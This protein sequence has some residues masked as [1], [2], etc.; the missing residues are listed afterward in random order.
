MRTRRA[1]FALAI[2]SLSGQPSRALGWTQFQSPQ[3]FERPL[4]L[5][6]VGFLG[7]V[8]IALAVLGERLI[9]WKDQLM[10]NFVE[11]ARRR[12]AEFEE[13]GDGI[14]IINHSG[15][16]EAANAAA[17]R[18][19]GQSKQS[20]ARLPVDD[21]LRLTNDGD[22]AFLGRLESEAGPLN[23]AP[24]REA[25]AKHADGVDM[26]VDVTIRSMHM[27]DGQYIGLY[28]RDISD[29]KQAE[30]LKDEFV[31]TVSHELRTPLTS[32]A[33]SLGLL[34]GGAVG[35][36]LPEGPARLIGIAH[37]NCQRLIRLINDMLD[38]EKIESG[39]MKFD[40]TPLTLAE[41][42]RRSIDAVRGFGDQLNVRVDLAIGDEDLSVRGDLDRLVQVGSNLISNAMKFSKAGDRIAITV[43]RHGRLARLSVKDQGPGIPE[44]FRARIFTKFAQADSSDTRQK[45]GTGLGLVIAKEIV[46]RHGG[47]LW[48][49][50]VVGQGA[51]FHVDLPLADAAEASPA[52]G[53]AER[54][55]ICEDDA[56]VA[57]VLKA[58]A[59][60]GRLRG[61]CGGDGGG[62]RRSRRSACVQPH[63]L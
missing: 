14:L 29:R 28:I 1:P 2:I 63:R 49:E 57:A 10:R 34:A 46:D 21:I 33:G 22:G 19:F 24:L 37:A 47:R 7:L 39:K 6:L 60:K 18:I 12:T 11:L 15:E 62:P 38:I 44:E 52:S 13:S 54:L 31:S 35:D 30:R 59:G 55:L 61:G 58:D 56:D 27:A 32:I 41:A 43:G 4:S 36:A 16:V 45:G 9:R 48:F 25:L 40:M 42:A 5:A 8:V 26:P 50:S 3:P 51:C 20:L 53:S 17:E 23:S